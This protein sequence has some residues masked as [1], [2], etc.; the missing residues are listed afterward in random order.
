ML[1]V[2]TT[3]LAHFQARCSFH[4]PLVF[5]KRCI[6][7]S[8]FNIESPT[9]LFFLILKYFL[10]RHHLLKDVQVEEVHE[11]EREST[12]ASKNVAKDDM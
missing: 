6:D 7:F 10:T 4:T 1:M 3:D 9:S 12:K 11:R 8:S 5:A 2:I